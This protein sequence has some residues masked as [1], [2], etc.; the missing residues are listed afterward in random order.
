MER[1]VMCSPPFMREELSCG[2]Y[3][4]HAEMGTGNEDRASGGMAQETGRDRATGGTNRTDRE[5]EGRQ[6]G[7]SA[8]QWYRALT[9]GGRGQECASQRSAGSHR[10]PR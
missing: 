2:N 5:R 4:E 3:F 7:G 1:R 9:A 8:Y 6:R 10:G